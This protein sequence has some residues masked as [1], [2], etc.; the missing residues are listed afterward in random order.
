[1]LLLKHSHNVVPL[2]PDNTA[3]SGDNTLWKLGANCVQGGLLS[4]AAFT[5]RT[6]QQ[7]TDLYKPHELQRRK[8]GEGQCG[9]VDL[10][11]LKK[12]VLL[13]DTVSMNIKNSKK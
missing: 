5:H 10:H 4:K 7:V 6:V 2:T 9:L 8:T 12:I 1:M 11:I 3:H 13:N